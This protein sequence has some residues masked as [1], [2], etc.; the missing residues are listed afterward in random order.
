MDLN[1][2]TTRELY[3]ALSLLWNRNSKIRTF[4]MKNDKRTAAKAD[5]VSY[6]TAN[7]NMS[8]IISA[9][10]DS[11]ASIKHIANANNGKAD[12][13]SC[14][15][16]PTCLDEKLPP[17]RSSKLVDESYQKFEQAQIFPSRHQ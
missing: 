6:L 10:T 17:Y 9:L 12:L 3:P 4:D 2:M 8:E 13:L 1:K 15:G 5:L 14:L 11:G 7:F 16:N